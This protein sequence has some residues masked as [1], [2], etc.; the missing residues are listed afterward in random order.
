[1]HVEVEEMTAERLQVEGSGMGQKHFQVSKNSSKNEQKRHVFCDSKRY[2]IAR[3]SQQS[4]QNA[5]YICQFKNP[6]ISFERE[7]PTCRS[8][9]ARSRFLFENL[10]MYQAKTLFLGP[11]PLAAYGFRMIGAASENPPWATPILK[12]RS[13]KE[14]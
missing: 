5:P 11:P 1:M 12:L 8:V 2:P 13:L 7:A 14:N 6:W 4:V 10:Q 9:G 3:R